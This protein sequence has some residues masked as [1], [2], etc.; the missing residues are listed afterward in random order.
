LSACECHATYGA[1]LR[2]KN[3]RVGWSRSAAGLDLSAEKSVQREL[4]KYRDA[5]RQ[6]IQ[7]DTT[8]TRDIERAVRISNE[9]G[10]AYGHGPGADS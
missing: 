7:P 6:G 10:S 2:D 3:I 9:T 5:R 1:H 4:A 8:R